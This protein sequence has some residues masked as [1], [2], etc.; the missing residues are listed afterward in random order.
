MCVCVC[1]FIVA[2]FYVKYLQLSIFNGE[3]RKFK[4]RG[5]IFKDFFCKQE[6]FFMAFYARYFQGNFLDF[7]GFF[8]SGRFQGIF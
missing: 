5:R 7:Q 4:S 8:V 1:S 2:L 6:Y 3:F